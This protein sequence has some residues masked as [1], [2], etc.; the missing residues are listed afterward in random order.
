MS[1]ILVICEK[2][3]QAKQFS[4]A[5]GK[6]SPFKRA[7]GYYENDNYVLTYAVGHILSSKQPSDYQEF[8]GWKWSAIPF[9]PPNGNL[10]YEPSKSKAQQLATIGELLNRGDIEYVVNGADAGREG[11]LIFWEIFDYFKSSLP[12]KRLWISSLVDKAII[13]GFNNLEDEAFF[14]PKR[15]AAYSR[16]YADW[17]LGMNLTVGFSI[18]AN[19]GRALHVGRVQTPT[20]ALLV[21]R[22]QEINNFVATDYYEIE[23]EFGGKYKGKWF[24]QEAGKNRFDKVED[25][26]AVVNK[27]TGKV[28]EVVK[29]DV[30]E[31]KVK[32]KTLYNLADLQRDANKKFGFTAKMTLDISQLLYER[33]TLLSYPRTDSRYLSA[34]HVPE[35]QPTLEALKVPNYEKYIDR[36]L[37]KPIVTSKHFV[38]D[39]KVSDH[40]AIIPTLKKADTSVFVDDHEKGV[41]KEDIQKLYD[42]VVKRFLSVFYTPA[43]YEKTEI[44]TEVEGEQFKTTGKILIDLGWKEVYGVEEEDDEEE[45]APKKGKKAEEKVKVVQ[46]PKI[47][48]GEKNDVSSVDMQ[49]KKTTPPSHY[50]EGELIG[51][52]ENPRKLLDDDDLKEA[53]KKAGAGLGTQATRDSI[54]ENIIKRGYVERKGKTMVATELAEKLISI[55]PI[56]LKS[57]EI[58]A[59]WEQ[60]LMDIEKSQMERDAFEREIRDYVTRSLEEL[61]G[62]ELTVS[63]GNVND[64]EV[65]GICPNCKSEVKEKKAV[66]ACDTKDCFVVFKEMAKKKISPAQV[67]QLLSKGE[68]AVLKGFKSKVGKSFEAKIV[69]KDGKVAFGFPEQT[70]EEFSVACPKC[71]GKMI[72][73]GMVVTCE[74]STQDKGCTTIFR[75]VSSKKLTNKQI[76]MLLSKG[77]TDKISGFKSKVG[78]PFDAVLKMDGLRAVFDFDNKPKTESKGTS[79]K[80]PFCAGN[81][82]ENAKAFG[83]SNWKEKNCKFTVWK[84]TM[85]KEIN[86][87]IVKTLI[88]K[89]KT[90]KVEGFKNKD[91]KEFSAYLVLNKE[92]K[93]IDVQYD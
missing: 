1:K 53:M 89:G 83:C 56:G 10:D 60:K 90:E 78:K 16:Q 33:Y 8:G 61:Q 54:I 67:K 93:K 31:Q 75:T 91:K 66:Y 32:P 19:M 24:T 15:A 69:I 18:K 6:A 7:T 92:E 45:D 51:V 26:E 2:P 70:N 37:S 12:V 48:M 88:E 68:T 28:G 77:K 65:V 9:F 29:K 81:V 25:A 50:T 57:P 46:L 71:Q 86:E 22:K 13:H 55:A 85:G 49:S 73:K 17:M 11:D 3:D 41:K 79:L 82:T 76:E 14:L 58:T 21:N 34:V 23:S 30:V 87:T 80:C 62:A 74:N 47:D 39:D 36:I 27:I 40:H 63:F 35:L 43:L 84:L 4:S 5:L 64:G 59:E 20:I 72:D 52:M 42:L 38:D 44:V